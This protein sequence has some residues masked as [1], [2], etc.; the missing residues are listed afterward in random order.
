MIF[1]FGG[2]KHFENN[3]PLENSPLWEGK[4]LARY[5]HHCDVFRDCKYVYGSPLFRYHYE[6]PTNPSLR[7]TWSTILITG[8][9]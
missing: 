3:L 2:P 4:N 9:K 8:G 7:E 5:I 6:V 1:S